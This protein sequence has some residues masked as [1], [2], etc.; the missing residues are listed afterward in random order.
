M[1]KKTILIIIAICFILAFGKGIIFG[2]DKGNSTDIQEVV[3][4]LSGPT[5]KIH[6]IDVGQANAAVV[7]YPNGNALLIDGGSK[8]SADKLIDYLLNI[9][10][11]RFHVIA[12]NN[13]P[14]NIGG[15]KKV[16]EKFNVID[17]TENGIGC[18][19][20][21]CQDL[22]YFIIENNIPRQVTKDNTS[23]IYGGANIK[24]TIL[25]PPVDKYS[26]SEKENS[27]VLRIEF[28]NSS[29]LFM[30]DCGFLCEEFLIGKNIDSDVLKVANHGASTSSS[31]VFLN[32]VK[33]MYSVISVGKN[34]YGYPNNETIYKFGR[35]GA[36]IHRTD[37]EGNII[38]MT[39]GTEYKV[40][41]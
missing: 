14:R 2:V 9:D 30:G 20:E 22:S 19:S 18:T 33:P 4:G 37:Q 21:I 41:I 39:N 31:E 3:T 1:E 29:F 16:L 25:N 40:L 17:Y 7:I 38:F 11:T 35:R 15:L 13:D 10:V 34:S 27:I 6:F 23:L 8:E 5:L 26:L 12:T 36:E 32:K 24:T 28:K